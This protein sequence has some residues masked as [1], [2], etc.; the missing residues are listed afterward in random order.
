M[1]V[2]ANGLEG[3]VCLWATIEFVGDVEVQRETCRKIGSRSVDLACRWNA[4]IEAVALNSDKVVAVQPGAI[5]AEIG[6][7]RGSVVIH[8]I[9]YLVLHQGLSQGS[10]RITRSGRPE[11]PDG[12]FRGLRGKLKVPHRQGD[13]D[14]RIALARSDGDGA[15]IGSRRAVRRTVRHSNV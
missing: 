13:R 10:Y 1:G 6:H 8:I 4:A 9:H 5:E 11:R 15:R 7:V 14:G 2:H 12:K 3:R